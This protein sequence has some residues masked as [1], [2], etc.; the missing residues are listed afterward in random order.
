MAWWDRWRTDRP[1]AP[2]G[3]GTTLAGRYR[4]GALRAEST[5]GR[6][7][8]ALD[9]RQDRVVMARLTRLPGPPSLA[10]RALWLARMHRG[11]EIARQITHPDVL[12]VLDG[13]M[14]DDEAWLITEAVQG[15]DL[16]RYTQP[17]RLLPDA[18]VLRV[19]ARIAHALAHA[20]ALGIVHRDL[21]PANV[22]VDLVRDVVKVADFG[23]TG[24]DGAP[25]TGS[26]LLRGTPAYM[27]PELLAGAPPAPACDAWSLGVLV[28]ELLSARRPHEATTLADL[29]WMTAR[30]SPQPLQ[31]LRPDLPAS[32]CAHVGM[33]LTGDPARRPASLAAWALAASGLAAAIERATGRRH[34]AANA[35]PEG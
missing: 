25:Q 21:K 14:L 9:L 31:P 5:Q 18:L 11:C 35:M 4:L 16:T 34:P 7:H 17:N 22:L 33:L 20:H 10:V 6:L 28:Y 23:I 1:D 19:A 24:M 12:R 8:E 30:Q 26:S 27:A 2:G 3:A 29:L 13:G 32:V 15:H